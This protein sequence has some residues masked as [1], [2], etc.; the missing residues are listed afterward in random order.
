MDNIQAHGTKKPSVFCTLGFDPKTK[1]SLDLG[2]R[3]RITPFE[4]PTV[5][6]LLPDTITDTGKK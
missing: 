6:S 1:N 2:R 3:L 4:G 5:M